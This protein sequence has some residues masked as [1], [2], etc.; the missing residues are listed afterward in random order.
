M[1]SLIAQ[2]S[3]VSQGNIIKSVTV[4]QDGSDAILN[5]GG[6]LDPTQLTG[7]IP[8]QNGK[9]KTFS[10]S[11]PNTLVDPETLP[12]PFIK[13][14]DDSILESAQ[15][16][17]NILEKGDD[18]VFVVELTLQGKK[19][20]VPELIQPIQKD[21]LRIRIK[22]FDLIQKQAQAE[23]KADVR[24]QEEKKNQ[25]ALRKTQQKKVASKSMPQRSMESKVEPVM[26]TVRELKKT[27]RK[28]A[29]MQVSILN[30]SGIAKRAY[31]LSVFFGDKQKKHIEGTLGIKL[32]II[33]ISNA[34]HTNMPR[35]T[36][37]FRENFLKS[38]L[39]LAQLMPGEQRIVP[40]QHQKERVGVDIEIYIGKD[41]K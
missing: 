30:A 15:V 20:L 6:V 18:V 12:S 28:P 10:I 32:D 41:Y 27:Y 22:D 3:S 7:A 4:T 2:S 11:L 34:M 29:L 36:V 24:K 5:I 17:E 38:A 26:K 14:G 23:K 8:K 13:F 40:M 21:N 25:K 35:T 16:K 37:Y 33:N 31:K 19:V 39:L 9:S 1:P